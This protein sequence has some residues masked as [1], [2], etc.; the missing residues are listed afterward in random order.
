MARPY[1]SQ[2][3]LVDFLRYVAL[4][5]KGALPSMYSYVVGQH[6]MYLSGLINQKI[7][8]PV[9]F[10]DRHSLLS[11]SKSI[12]LK[13]KV[14]SDGISDMEALLIHG[15]SRMRITDLAG[16]EL[17]WVHVKSKKY[18]AAL[19]NWIRPK[20]K[21]TA[22]A[23]S[24]AKQVLKPITEIEALKERHR[25]AIEFH[26][27][28][29]NELSNPVNQRY[30]NLSKI[31]DYIDRHRQSLAEHQSA[32]AGNGDWGLVDRSLGVLDA[33]HVINR[34]SLKSFPDAWVL[35]FPVPAD[36]NRGF[37]R[38]VERWRT[39]VLKGTKRVNLEPLQAF[40]LFSSVMPNTN[41]EVNEVMKAIR[42]QIT[43]PVFL[44]KMRTEIVKAVKMKP[45]AI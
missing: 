35:L 7:N 44:A 29:I 14:I 15:T 26:L 2:S 31:N 34:A 10:S 21:S 28:A 4:K 25:F 30:F 32:L 39:A 22:N 18:R 3:Y 24:L 33:D 20:E 12:G 37:G 16:I 42:G 27:A 36:A 8:V 13:H 45:L 6:R 40:K 11:W 23:V 43:N 17:I 19:K 41:D 38:K 9:M 5:H 1:Q